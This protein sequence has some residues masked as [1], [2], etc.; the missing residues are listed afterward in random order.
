VGLCLELTEK[1][2]GKLDEV[3]RAEQAGS[4]ELR[5]QYLDFGE[6]VVE[7][8]K[9]LSPNSRHTMLSRGWRVAIP[10]LLLF[11]LGL[12]GALGGY[13]VGRVV[14]DRAFEARMRKYS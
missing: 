12:A 1:A 13:F 14:Q 11:G 6:I 10:L 2:L 4:D 5:S 3:A 8:H 7:L 9:E